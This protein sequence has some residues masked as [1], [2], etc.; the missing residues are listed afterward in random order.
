[1]IIKT[2]VE[3]TTNKEDLKSEHGLSL[4]IE[5]SGKRILFDSGARGLFMENAIK[6][7]INISDIDYAVISHGHN[8]H[9][10]GLERFLEAN[11][12][13]E[14]FI[15][16]NAFNKHYSL[17]NGKMEFIGLDEK[18]KNNK[19]LIYVKGRFFI[20]KNIEV[21]SDVKAKM[22]LPVTNSN[23]Y[24]E[25]NGDIVLDDFSH[26]LNLSISED[27][28]YFLLTGCSHNGIVNIME[29]YK[30]LKGY[31]PQFVIGGLH[32]ANSNYTPTEDDAYIKE[33]LKYMSV[34]Q[35]FFYTCHCTGQDVFGIL[36]KVLKDKI[37]YLNTGKEI[38][39]N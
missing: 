1:M 2:L 9:G 39:I 27:N 7:D 5:T 21:F 34:S 14:V 22:P 11:S 13:A 29:H 15:H 18:L 3:D 16:S 26:E 12:K 38:N 32:L 30:E 6:M 28:R 23:L 8:D 31:M 19:R 35:S 33:L 37:S 17:R 4:Y 10:G 25:N 20:W 24:A 36:S